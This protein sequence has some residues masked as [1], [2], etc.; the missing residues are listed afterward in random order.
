MSRRKT[1][2]PAASITNERQTA[3]TKADY[4]TLASMYHEYGPHELVRGVAALLETDRDLHVQDGV[5][6]LSKRVHDVGDDLFRLAEV[7]E[8][9][10]S[11]FYGIA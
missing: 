7:Q 10:G 2:A 1:P 5:H 11:P 8:A 3:L 9:T 6:S 4:R